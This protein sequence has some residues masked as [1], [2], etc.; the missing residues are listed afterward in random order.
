MPPNGVVSL[1]VS[2]GNH[3][4][5]Y[6]GTINT[7]VYRSMNYGIDW[8]PVNNGIPDHTTVYS[9]VINTITPNTLYAGTHRGVFK[10][11][12]GGE[13]WTSA[14]NGLTELSVNSLA[15][16]PVNPSTIYAGA[17]SKV[18]K[19]IDDAASWTPA[20]AGPPQILSLAVAPS[21][22]SILYAGVDGGLGLLRSLDGGK[23]WTFINNGL[24]GGIQ[25][26]AVA[27]DPINGNTVYI[28]AANGGVWKTT[29]GG[30]NWAPDNRGLL[31]QDVRDLVMDPV[32]PSKVYAATNGGGV[33]GKV[34]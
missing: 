15:I 2:P 13:I 1:A 17:F 28:G 8:T 9:L 21:N 29:N 11:T 25:V 24:P 30:T 27:I 12:D 34:P 31:N 20:T 4:T 10:S 6:A 19:S 14:N 22:P 16:D 5:V 7:G 3:A 33:Y 32:T 18:F 23:T 26:T